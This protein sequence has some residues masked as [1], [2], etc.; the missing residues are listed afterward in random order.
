MSTAALAVLVGLLLAFG[1]VRASH[2]VPHAPTITS[3]TPGGGSLTIVWTAPADTGN[4]TISAYDVRTT[5][6]AATNKADDQ[7]DVVDDASTSD[8]L[9]YTVT[10]LTA[11]VEFDVQVRAVNADGDGD[12]SATES[13]TP[14]IEG[15][16]ISSITVGDE[17]LTV[18]WTA[19]SNIDAATITAYDLRYILTATTDQADANWS[20]VEN[21]WTSG[22]QVY[23]LPGLANG[24]GYDVQVRAAVGSDGQ[25]STTAVG[26]PVEHGDTLASATVLTLDTPVGG[27][28]DPGTDVDYFRFVLNEAIGTHDFYNGRSRYRRRTPG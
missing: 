3:I 17:A 7:W 12:W 11:D 8:N 19:P 16:T 15:P 20:V 21:I 5:N 23:V 26:T 9:T 28:I 4:S 2:S 18:V 14:L 10:G 27:V 6:T 22:A 25:W 13:E 24:I 1:G